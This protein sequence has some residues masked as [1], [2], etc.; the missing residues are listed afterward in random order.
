MKNLYRDTKKEFN[1]RF[2]IMVLKEKLDNISGVGFL[3][4]KINIPT[5][6][7]SGERSNYINEDL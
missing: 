4:K 1:W 3:D 2:N 7:L 6:F 5:L